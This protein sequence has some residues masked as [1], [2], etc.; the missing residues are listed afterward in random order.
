[1][2]LYQKYAGKADMVRFLVE[3]DADI[4]ANNIFRS[5]PLEIADEMGKCSEFILKISNNL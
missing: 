5:T 2:I 3:H 1:M 4:N